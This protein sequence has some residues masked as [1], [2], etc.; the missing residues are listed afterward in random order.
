MEHGSMLTDAPPT[1]DHQHF[2]SR[3]IRF[4]AARRRHLG[5][6]APKLRQ[7]ISQLALTPRDKELQT[8]QN[9]GISLLTLCLLGMY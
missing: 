6:K 3:Q 1:C 4:Q 2:K 9:Y 8:C 7:N 5:A